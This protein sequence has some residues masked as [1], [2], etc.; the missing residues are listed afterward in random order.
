MALSDFHLKNFLRMLD[1]SILGQHKTK[2]EAAIDL[3]WWRSAAQLTVGY[4]Y[5]RL[6]NPGQITDT[7]P[8]WRRSWACRRKT[9][10]CGRVSP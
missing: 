4:A 8:S 2:C 10:S 3:T 7:N 9:I 6:K 5:Q 1:R